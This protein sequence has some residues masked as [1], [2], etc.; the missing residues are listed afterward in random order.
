MGIVL[1]FVRLEGKLVVQCGDGGRGTAASSTLLAVTGYVDGGLEVAFHEKTRG[2]R[3]SWADP[4][5]KTYDMFYKG[6]CVLH[7]AL[8]LFPASVR[9]RTHPLPPHAGSPSK[10]TCWGT[11]SWARPAT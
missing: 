9:T 5:E 4:N 6:E 1:T 2:V 7:P 10:T 8:L 3:M 11:R